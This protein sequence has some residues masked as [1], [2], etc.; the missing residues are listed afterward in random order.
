MLGLF[1]A[2]GGQTA[3]GRVDGVREVSGGWLIGLLARQ[4]WAS[5]ITLGE[6]VLYE[7]PELIPVLHAHEM[8]HVHQYRR[9]GPLFLPAYGLES[10]FQWLRT[11]DGYRSN[12]FEAAAYKISE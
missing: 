7:R 9:W 11:G 10:A 6:V 8:V 2:L 12:R 3:A 1:G 5:A 4:G